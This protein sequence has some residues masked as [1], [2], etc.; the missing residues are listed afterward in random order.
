MIE[1]VIVPRPRSLSA[2]PVRP[3][4]ELGAKFLQEVELGRDVFHLP[5]DQQRQ[6]VV[7]FDR[8]RAAVG[9]HCVVAC[10]SQRLAA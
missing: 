2:L 1:S 5:R 10:P 6:G 4:I 9:G 3:A 8:P 7:G